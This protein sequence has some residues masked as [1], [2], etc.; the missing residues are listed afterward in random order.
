MLIYFNIEFPKTHSINKLVS[1]LQK[2]NIYIPIK[3]NDIVI[4]SEYAV[5]TRYP[6]DYEPISLEETTNAIELAENT[7][8]WVKEIISNERMF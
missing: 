6:G 7:L 1:C 3:I 4:L 8:D 2:N 5:E